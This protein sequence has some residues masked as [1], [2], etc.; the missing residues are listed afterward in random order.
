MEPLIQQ[1]TPGNHLLRHRGDVLTFTLRTA[2]PADGGAWLRTNLGQAERLRQQRVDHI[3]T[4]V[5]DVTFKHILLPVWMAA[6][7]YR[8]QTYRFVVN[9]Q[10]GAVRGERPYS[11]IKIAVA[12]AIGLIVAAA[13]GAILAT[14]G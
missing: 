11:K 4:D 13:I 1:P 2:F 5:S 6:Y 8:G 12:I 14:N 7:K 3:E 10:S 9:G